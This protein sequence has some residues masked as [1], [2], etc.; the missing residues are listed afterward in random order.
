MAT[1]PRTLALLAVLAAALA[2]A[3]AAPQPARGAEQLLATMTAPGS[4]ARVQTAVSLEQGRTYRLVLGA[5]VTL[6]YTT[7][8]RREDV[9][10]LYCFFHAGGPPIP[11]DD[12]TDQPP[13]PGSVSPLF[14]DFGG[15]P[16]NRRSPTALAGRALPYAADHEY[17]L[18]FVA[19]ASGPLGAQ[20]R[21]FLNATGTGG[22]A[23]E[24]YGEAPVPAT[25]PPAPAVPPGT[26][27]GQPAITGPP[28]FRIVGIDFAARG[29]TTFHSGINGGTLTPRV[30]WVLGAGDAISVLPVTGRA[31]PAGVKLQAI[32]GGA[33]FTITG[34]ILSR[35]DGAPVATPGYFEVERIPR[36]REG[37]VEMTAFGPQGPMRTQQAGAPAGASLLTPLARVDVDDGVARV[38]HS[39]TR[40]RTR[41]GN[42]RGG[43]AVT[44][45]DP[46]LAGLRLVPGRQVDV[47]RRAVGRPFPLVPDLETT[48]PS[49]REVRAGPVAVTGPAQLSLR[50]LQHSKCVAVVVG[51]TRPARVLVTIFSGRRSVRLFGQRLVVF[52]AA[53]RTRT[54]IQVPR[55]ARTFDVRTPLRFAVGYALGAR[56]RPGQRA[57]DPVIRPIR[58]VP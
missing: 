42:V 28:L 46:A 36:L 12:C 35:G 33:T 53:G 57:T 30:G 45:S 54:C 7:L 34:T 29:G 50:S 19:P 15:D 48:I 31:G 2:V 6:D 37:E 44:P 16:A 43:V 13:G 39:A 8:G 24:L 10:A 27:P 56:S 14:L 1:R 41:V 5:T 32:S 23:I 58:L 18:T 47:T 55:R 4:G 40:A 49:P 3:V 38:A 21:A 52:R 51:S 22:I 25:P 9:D 11:G 17:D 26:P 20:V